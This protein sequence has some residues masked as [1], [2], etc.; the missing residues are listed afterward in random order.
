MLTGA[1]ESGE[2]HSESVLTSLVAAKVDVIK[3]EMLGDDDMCRRAAARVIQ[4]LLDRGQIHP[5]QCFAELFALH[6]DPECFQLVHI[7][8]MQEFKKKAS[9]NE[10][11]VYRGILLSRPF[12]GSTSQLTSTAS[13]TLGPDCFA[14]C[15]RDFVLELGVRQKYGFLQRLAESPFSAGA[16]ADLNKCAFLCGVIAALPYAKQ[17]EVLF[18]CNSVRR[19]AELKATELKASIEPVFGPVL[20]AIHKNGGKFEDNTEVMEK[21]LLSA[22]KKSLRIALA[23]ELCVFLKRTYRIS[24]TQLSRSRPDPPTEKDDKASVDVTINL[25]NI[26]AFCPSFDVQEASKIAETSRNI[27]TLADKAVRYMLRAM[28]M[29]TESDQAGSSSKSELTKTPSIARKRMQRMHSASSGRDQEEDDDNSD[30][31][32]RSQITGSSRTLGSIGSSQISKKKKRMP[33]MPSS[34]SLT[35]SSSQ[36]DQDFIAE[37]RANNA[38]PSSPIPAVATIANE[39]ASDLASKSKRIAKK[40]KLDFVTMDN[41]VSPIE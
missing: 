23:L 27:V 24:A 16:Q 30:Y 34:G 37:R 4:A 3:K 38:S 32:E 1:K 15:Y 14:D 22:V 36:L 5:E 13:T 35:T 29:L 26:E 8:L 18:I 20:K 28:R 17:S 12:K 40:P 41:G 11:Q 25:Q 39:T 7:I 31:E 2:D 33:T 21:D 10:A 9:L 6:R 19:D